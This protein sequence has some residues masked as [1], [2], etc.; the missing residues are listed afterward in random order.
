VIPDDLL[1][2]SELD[3]GLTAAQRAVLSREEVASIARFGILLEA[4]LISGFGYRL[5]LSSDV[6]DPRFVYALHE[7][8]EETRHSTCSSGWSMSWLRPNAT[9][10]T[11]A[12]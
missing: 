3:C 6:T 8:G 5:A 1:S 7:L 12:S 10:S 2:I 9:C 4:V 11:T